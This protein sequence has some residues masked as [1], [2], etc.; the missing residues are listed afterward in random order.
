[1]A[2]E[3]VM[4]R[5]GL[6]METGRVVEW[7]KQDG[8]Y[9]EQDELLFVVETDKASLE[10]EAPVS[11]V[12]HIHPRYTPEDDLPIGTVIGKLAARGEPVSWEPQGPPASPAEPTHAPSP[13]QPP[14]VAGKKPSSPAAKRLARELKIDL[15]SV[16]GSGE[17]GAVLLAD[18]RRAAE[19]SAPVRISPIARQ[20]AEELGVDVRAVAAAHPGKRLM[21]KHIEQAAPAP[22][23]PSSERQPTTRMRRLIARR[24]VE[25][26]RLTAPVTHHT[27]VDATELV[28]LRVSLKESWSA[29]PS[30]TD[31]VIK[32]AAIALTEHPTLNARLDGDEIVLSEAVHVGV[33]V[34][35]E[36]GLVVPV[37]R[38][39]QDKTLRQI[40]EV[41]SARVEEAHRGSLNPD[42]LQGGTFTVTNLGMYD[43][44]AFTPIINL[45]ECAILGLGRIL[46]KPVVIDGEARRIAVRQMM[47]LS[48]TFDHRIVDG[49]P[50]ARFLQRVKHLIE[51]P[52]LWLVG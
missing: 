24:M 44:D 28:N 27:E 40:A 48:L 8:E 23:G 10:V 13:V 15:Q 52:Y 18:V 2:Y 31:V 20:V 6:T 45:P 16:E 4:P 22:A 29:P 26:S 38:D 25:S 33:A 49:A 43:V 21:R 9:V 12:L 46:S 42:D 39:V 30:Y 36:R 3:I 34:D 5:L 35:T 47:T 17:D 50:A 14:T 41:T 51:R 19:A 7:Y 1:M 32:I 37:V 11:G